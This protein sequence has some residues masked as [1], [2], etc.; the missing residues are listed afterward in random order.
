MMCDD[1]LMC[2]LGALAMLVIVTALPLL[3]YW[4]WFG[5]AG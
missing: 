5:L 3:T 4:L 2:L 1:L